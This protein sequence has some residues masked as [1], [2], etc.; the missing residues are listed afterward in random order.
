MAET[1]IA[2][3]R[4][5][6][7]CRHGRAPS[8]VPGEAFRRLVRTLGTATSA[9]RTFV[10]AAIHDLLA[11]LDGDSCT[12]VTDTDPGVT[13]LSPFS[14]NYLCGMVECTAWR[15]GVRPPGWTRR[16][17]PLAEPWFA[18]EMP[19]LRLHLLAS[20]PVPFRQRNI[21]IDSMVGS[22]V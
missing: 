5:T 22:R 19:G 14:A 1:E 8:P 6:D 21:F 2:E 7:P 11:K 20:S 17:P 15:N 12:A 4:D 3:R 13:D 9:E 18:T 10:L 16:V